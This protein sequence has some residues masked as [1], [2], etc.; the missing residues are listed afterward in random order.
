MITYARSR[1]RVDQ[2]DACLQ[3]LPSY[4]ENGYSEEE[5][6]AEMPKLN[7]RINLGISSDLG[8]TNSR[9]IFH[10]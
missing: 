8:I 3:T 7:Q 5:I 1:G 2:S 9:F 6:V 4:P 10:F